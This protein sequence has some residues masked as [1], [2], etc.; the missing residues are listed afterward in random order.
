MLII[1]LFNFRKKFNANY[2]CSTFQK[3]AILCA[4]SKT[5]VDYKCNEALN[6]ERSGHHR[7]LFVG[8][9]ISQILCRVLKM[10]SD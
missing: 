4:E 3:E 6:T 2:L 1:N 5:K 7:L 8:H 10:F 9:E